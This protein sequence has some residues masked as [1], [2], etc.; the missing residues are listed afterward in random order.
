MMVSRISIRKLTYK[1]L[2]LFPL[3]RFLNENK[4]KSLVTGFT[5]CPFWKQV[6]VVTVKIQTSR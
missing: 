4:R 6:Q 5:T 3:L 1:L 2:N